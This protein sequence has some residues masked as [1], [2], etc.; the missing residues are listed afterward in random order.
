MARLLFLQQVAFEYVGVMSLS[1]Y[2]KSKGHV[3]DILI[4]SEEG[5][6]FYDKV[7]DFNA[8]VIAFS[9]M[10]GSHTHYLKMA[11]E[12][13]KILDVPVI[14][15]GPHP[16]FFPEMIEHPSVDAIC[17]GEG[18]EA[19]TEVLNSRDKGEHFTNTDNCW[20]KSNGEIVRNEIRCA[21]TDLDDYPMPDRDLYYKYKFLREYPTKPFISGRG[22]PYSCSFCFNQEYNSLYHGKMKLVRRNS[23]ARVVQEI[24]EVK[25]K[26]P[27]NRVLFQDDI[28]VMQKDWLEEFAPMYKKKIGLSYIANVRADLIDDA[29][30]KLIKDSGCKVVTWGIE[31]G[32]EEIRTKILNKKFSNERIIEAAGIMRKH[33]LKVKAFNFLGSPGETFEQAMETV[34]LNAEVKT[35]YPWCSI[36]QPYPKTKIAQIAQ[37]M[38]SLKADFSL[39]DIQKSYFSESVFVNKD[40]KRIVRLQKLF[41]FGVKMP[42][43]IPMIRLITYVP[44]KPVYRFLFGVSFLFRWMK[45]TDTPFFKAVLFGLRH[46]KSF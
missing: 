2:V 44:M 31:S 43:L 10:T 26:Y 25:E 15:G 21:V 3:C 22:C 37:E 5:K 41:Y 38:G 40:I 45:E 8:D 18:E 42:W 12:V 30:M 24:L 4:E 36:L 17:R 23:P 14:F 19:L 29:K 20:V 16:T 28:F 9:T 1:A 6:D 39:D 33:G 46:N 35:D 27:L 11:D 32:N 7:S 13:K 34:K